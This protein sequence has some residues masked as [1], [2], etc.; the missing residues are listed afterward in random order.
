[1]ALRKAINEFCHQC[2]VDPCSPGTALQQITLCESHGCPL[3]E[4]RPITKNNI[5]PS[6]LK[7]HYPEIDQND[8]FSASDTMIRAKA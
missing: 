3:H 8:G 4:V 5:A 2:I 7:W 1:M 6:V